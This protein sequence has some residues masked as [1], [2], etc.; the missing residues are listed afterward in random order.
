[1]SNAIFSVPDPANAPVLGYEPGSAERDALQAEYKRQLNERVEIPLVIGGREV[2]TGNTVDVTIPH[3]HGTVIATCHQAGPR[4]IEMAIDA[5]LDAQRDWSAMPWSERAA[6]FLR[7]ADLLAGPWRQRLNAS[8]ML[9][10]SKTCHQA[11]IDAACELIDFLKFNCMY[12][13]GMYAGEQPPVSPEGV[14]NRMELRPLEGF[15]YSVTP[16]NFTSI[17]INLSTAP[18]LMG[19]T[20]IWKPSQASLL[21]NYVGMQL[22]EAA[23]LPAGVINFLPGEPVDV[24]AAMLK[25]PSFAGMH[26]TGSTSVFRH[27]WKQMA[28]N[29]GAYRS[30]PRVVGETGGKDFIVVHPSSEDQSVVTAMI[31]GAYEFQGQKCSAASRAYIPRSMWDRIKDQLVAEIDGITQ[32]DVGEFSNYMGAVIHKASFEKCK[33]YIDRAKASSDAEVIAGGACDSSKGWFV[34]PTL[35]QASTPNYESMAEEIFGPI[36]TVYVY[37]DADWQGM[38]EIVDE[39]SPYG[40]TGAVF[41]TD[42]T[43]IAQAMDTLRYAAGNFYI[44]DK[45]TG[46]VVG[47]QPFGGARASGTNDKAGS[48][49]NLQRWVSPR[50]IKETFVP[51]TNYRYGFLD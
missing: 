5:A 23:G 46:A 14:W 32:G 27:L 28:D 2:R 31:R 15:I 35:I 9:N 41:A 44:N 34:R 30:Y 17:A 11:E 49:M 20:T 25:H 42:R 13:E 12:A 1:M 22:L 36:L 47:Q 39:T 50:T 51:A 18:A 38:L 6:V 33:G 45:P 8:T 24:T 43:A 48:A 4:E 21:S 26:Y 10:Q 16:F 29:L 7:A 19:N 37:E 40:L 3:D